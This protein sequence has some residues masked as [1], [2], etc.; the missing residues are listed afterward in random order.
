[1]VNHGPGGK[2]EGLASEAGNGFA[3]HVFLLGQSGEG[4][5]LASASALPVGVW[6]VREA[7]EEKKE[8]KAA[9]VSASK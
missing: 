6:G 9:V 5:V 1:M 2:S 8:L 4:K 7:G 3:E